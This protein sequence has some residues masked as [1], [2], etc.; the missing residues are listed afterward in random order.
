MDQKR[1]PGNFI[2]EIANTGVEATAILARFGPGYRIKNIANST[3]LS[4]GLLLQVGRD[5]NEHEQ[6]FKDNFKQ[7]FEGA[8][9]KCKKEYEQLVA[10]VE[11]VNSF[12]KDESDEN[13]ETLPK[14]HWKRV[15]W[16]LS[17]TDDEFSDFEDELDESYKIA[18]M[19]QVIVQLVILQVHAQK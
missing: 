17:M 7:K 18:M 2:L 12:K 3:S 6:L 4:A 9:S 15:A 5:V 1:C 13:A 16:G 14:K 19:A 8:L 11:K 10:A